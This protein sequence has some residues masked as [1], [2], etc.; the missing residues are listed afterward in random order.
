M[1]NVESP[2]L[3]ALGILTQNPMSELNK[4]MSE[5]YALDPPTKG[6]FL[7]RWVLFEDE[8]ARLQQ[9]L[10][11]WSWDAAQP[12]SAVLKRPP[13]VS[14][15]PQYQ[16]AAKILAWLQHASVWWPEAE[17]IGWADSDTW[18]L[19]RRV[20]SLLEGVSDSLPGA[21]EAWIGHFM[22]WARYDKSVLDGL[23]FMYSSS[24]RAE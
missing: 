22:H 18:L 20:Q 5:S 19:P 24:S 13:F 11:S 15:L 3:A 21:K 8:V 16:C 12:A 4:R 9:R 1:A 23:G 14:S 17:F 10:P 2:Q 6:R 7:M